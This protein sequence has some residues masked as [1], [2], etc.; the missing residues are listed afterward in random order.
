MKIY[1]NRGMSGGFTLVEVLIVVIVIGVLAGF[2]ALSLTAPVDKTQ[3]AVCH[4]NQRSFLSAYNAESVMNFGGADIPTLVQKAVED[5]G[6]E[7]RITLESSSIYNASLKGL[8]QSGGTIRLLLAKAGDETENPTQIF[9]TYHDDPSS[10][11]KFEASWEAFVKQWVEA[12]GGTVLSGSV[13]RKLYEDY[14]AANPTPI[15]M[16]QKYYETY[17]KDKLFNGV[18]PPASLYWWSYPVT[19]GV[20]EV[21]YTVT[22]ANSYSDP[23]AWWTGV[24]RQSIQSGYVVIVD[25]VTYIRT[26][27]D[28]SPGSASNTYQ[29]KEALVAKMKELG[30][31]T[32]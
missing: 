10:Q 7:G 19:N 11:Y 28:V 18:R 9:C 17:I 3:E 22:F 14:Y 15:P 5:C 2:L 30:Y 25:G 4:A 6:I 8:C 21:Q 13:K 12:N 16:T 31:V 1:K 23:S 29:T 20:G 27:K 26:G 32:L 24:G